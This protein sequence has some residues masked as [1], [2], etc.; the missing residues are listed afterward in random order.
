[1]HSGDTSQCRLCMVAIIASVF[2]RYKILLDSSELA[3][4]A[5]GLV[6]GTVVVYGSLAETSEGCSVA[7]QVVVVR[8][9]GRWWC[10]RNARRRGDLK[11]RRQPQWGSPAEAVMAQQWRV[12][13]SESD[14]SQ[15]WYDGGSAR[16]PIFGR[17]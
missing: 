4:M 10:W 7:C 3:G 2:E 15:R 11:G 9:G 12:G 13:F 6:F 8:I 17:N 16:L 14:S 5:L 1:M